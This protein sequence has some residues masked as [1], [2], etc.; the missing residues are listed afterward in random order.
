SRVWGR[1]GGL[2][3]MRRLVGGAGWGGLSGRGL[4]LFGGEVI[5]DVALVGQRR[6]FGR[7][8]PPAVGGERNADEPP[9]VAH[10]NCLLSRGNL[11]PSMPGTNFN[12]TASVGG[13][14][15]GTTSSMRSRNSISA[16]SAPGFS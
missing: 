6:V 7:G 1:G 14:V 13:T 3:R 16:W 2:G 15:T 10:L 11:M 12:G 9:G 8:H 4:G 5:Q